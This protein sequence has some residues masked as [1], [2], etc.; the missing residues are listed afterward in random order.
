MG[1]D[2]FVEKIL[3]QFPE[4]TSNLDTEEMNV[5]Q[6]AIKNGHKNITK[7][8]L[9]KFSRN[10]PTIPSGLLSY[11]HP[12]TGNTILHFAAEKT[13]EDEGFALQMQYELQWLE[14]VKEMVPNDLLHCRNKSEKTAEELFTENHKN[15]VKSGKGQ[16]TDLGK[17]CS[18]LVAA[19]VFASSFSIPGDKDANQ[20]PIFLHRTAFKVFS[21]AYVIGLSSAAASLV[22]F[23]SFLG[24]S[25]KEHDFRRSLPTK[26][27]LANVSFLITL[28]ALLVAF[29]C[30]IYLQIY[31]GK[32]VEKHDIIPFVCE[33][34]FFPTVCLLVVLYRS[35]ITGIK[36][37]LQN[38]W[39]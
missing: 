15:M 16:L 39:R 1:F 32:R 22:L 12:A 17:T 21:H 3:D 36:S 28:V 14:R 9:S 13:E 2:E 35:P 27:V 31:G 5:L 37:F 10:N 29:S 19:V 8:I 26:Y 33:L 23:L 6:V 20:D 18:G 7:L 25:Y 38:F 4:S 24:S 11:V 30:N 34:T